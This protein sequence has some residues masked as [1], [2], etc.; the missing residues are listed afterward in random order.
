MFELFCYWIVERKGFDD[1]I[2]EAEA[3]ET[4]A[5]DIC[6]GLHWDL[7]NLHLFAAQLQLAEVQDLAMD[8]IQDLYLRRNWDI[9]PA[10]VEYVYQECDPGESCRLRKWIVASKQSPPS[11]KKPPVLSLPRSPY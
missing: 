3:D 7:V 4:E 11:L 2:D 1:F 10:L 8:A 6:E 9:V 5:D